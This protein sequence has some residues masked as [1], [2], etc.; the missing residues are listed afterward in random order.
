M[1]ALKILALI[2]FGSCTA[3]AQPAQPNILVLIADDMG[4]EDNSLYGSRTVPT[5]R[6]AGLA[7]QGMLFE[8]AF[9]TTSSCSPSR[10]SLMSGLYPH[11]TGAEDMHQP[12]PAGISVLPKLMS[13]AGYRTGHMLKTHYGPYVDSQ[14]DWYG[15]KLGDIDAFLDST[16][17]KPFFLWMGFHDPHRPYEDDPKDQFSVDPK[18]V[19]VRP[20]L[21]PTPGTRTELAAYMR[22]IRRLDHDIGAVLDNLERRGL[23]DNTI[24]VFLSDNGAP[25]PREKGSVYDAGVRTPLIVRWPRKIAAGSRFQKLMSTIDLTPTILDL[26]GARTPAS[27]AGQSIAPVLFGKAL[28]GRKYVFSERNWHGTD[29][30]IRSVRTEDYRFV[31]NAYVELPF[32]NPSDLS[33]SQSFRD[34]IALRER[35]RLTP[36]Q[37]LNFAAPRPLVEL[38]YLPADPGEYHNLAAKAEHQRKATELAR[39]LEQWSKS[40]GDFPPWKRRRADTSDRMT[41][42]IFSDKIPPLIDE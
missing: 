37:E 9:L 4:W 10:I 26:A 18:K 7:S 31:L 35:G 2:V 5:P 11:Q 14:F 6:L 42:I 12:L 3:H 39:V 1:I 38:Y 24:V 16:G 33:S 8:Q 32:P 13:D 25:F 15:K 19:P 23:A 29:A 27:M 21:A 34:M 41:G 30:H 17:K 22:A 36:Q 28:E 20:Q 40:T